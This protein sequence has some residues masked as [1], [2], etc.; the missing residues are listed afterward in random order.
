MRT[1]REPLHVDSLLYATARKPAFFP[2]VCPLNANDCLRAE[3]ALEARAGERSGLY[4]ALFL[5][6]ALCVFMP[7]GVALC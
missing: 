2:R 7:L 6:R 4:E 3:V 5:D 1:I